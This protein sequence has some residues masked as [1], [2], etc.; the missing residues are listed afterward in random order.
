MVDPRNSQLVFVAT[1]RTGILVSRDGGSTFTA[2]NR[3]FSHRQVTAVLADK[4]DPGRLYVAMI[5]NREY[6][7]IY[8]STNAGTS[9][10]SMNAGLGT[11][12][13]FSLKQTESGALVA[14]TNQGV[15]TL[16]R[17]SA[18]WKPISVT[19][20]EKTKM[21]AVRVRKKGGPKTVEH[22]DWIKGEISG[23]VLDVKTG[24]TK[25]FA[26]SSQ[27]LYRSLDRGKSWTGGPVLDRKEFVA[28]DAV[29]NKVLAASPNAVMLSEDGGKTWSELKLPNYVSRINAV[30]IGP[31]SDVWIVTHMGAFRTKDA[32]ASWQHE[33][34]GQPVTNLTY[35]TY[36]D[37][38]S[39][40][41]AVASGKKEV[42]ESRDGGDT[43]TLAASSHWPIR[44]IAVSNGR[45]LAVTDFN[46]V[47]AQTE[48]LPAMKSAG[49]G[50]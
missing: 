39:R 47:L 37:R 38:N 26:A 44:N 29:D 12:D 4:H 40:L 5:N 48:T 13:I 31:K 2:S 18:D 11:R 14:G 28:V 9:W 21:V 17:N 46:G 8:L 25:W 3:G 33:M 34:L 16:E 19:L 32:G 20:S 27:G 35:V 36:D 23:R 50:N 45:M 7:G 24:E 22:R 42:F 6:G 10:T 1:D 49:G 43:W 15:F 30:T 41:L